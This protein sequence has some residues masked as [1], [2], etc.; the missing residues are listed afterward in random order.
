MDWSGFRVSK[1]FM[2]RDM[3]AMGQQSFTQVTL[4]HR[5]YGG[6]LETCRYYRLDQG[7]VENVSEGTWLL[8][9]AYS[10]YVP[11]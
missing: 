7:E 1:H 11:W 4:V 3:S 8:V 5:D 2:A 10:E 6:L 9:S